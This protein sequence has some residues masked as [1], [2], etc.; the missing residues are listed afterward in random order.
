MGAPN[1]TIT[2]PAP[3][4]STPLINPVSSQA[5]QSWQEWF[6][7]VQK[8][9]TSFAPPVSQDVDV[10]DEL[11]GEIAFP[12]DGTY[13]I[14]LDS[15]MAKSILEI[16][17]RS[18]VGTTTLTPKINGTTL[19]GG[20]SSV[21]TAKA[22]VAHSTLNAMAVGDELTFVLSVTSATC[23]NLAFTVKYTRKITMLQYA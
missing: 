3:P 13:S 4:T 19:G 18:D 22:T 14:I 8:T 10:V 5:D 1:W 15:K 23:S 7:A 2:K 17:T 20:A 12:S 21:T 9:L 11:T 16:T 6:Q